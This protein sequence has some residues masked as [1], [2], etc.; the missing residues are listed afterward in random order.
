[1]IS[2]PT[3]LPR[4]VVHALLDPGAIAILFTIYKLHDFPDGNLVTII[5]TSIT[6][7]VNP[8]STHCQRLGTDKQLLFK[9]S[10]MLEVSR[11]PVHHL[12]DGIFLIVDD[13]LVPCC[14]S[15]AIENPAIYNQTCLESHLYFSELLFSTA[16]L[17]VP[18]LNL[19]R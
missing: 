17:R 12:S 4:N 6:P 18:T 8:T 11:W 13:D 7:V 1:L 19:T 9:D 16:V 5:H 14:R 2:L 10:D 3:Y 15:L